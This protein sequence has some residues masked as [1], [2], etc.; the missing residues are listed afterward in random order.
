MKNMILRVVGI[1]LAITMML[2]PQ[3]MAA[4]LSGVETKITMADG[5]V[6]PVKI[7]GDEF[8]GFTETMDGYT[9]LCS[10]LG[11]DWFYAYRDTAGNLVQSTLRVG[12]ADPE[13]AMLKKHVRP[14]VT[15]ASKERIRRARQGMRSVTL[16]EGVW[17]TT[18]KRVGITIIV[19]FPDETTTFTSED[20]DRLLNSDGYTEYGNNGSVKAYF[21]DMSDNKLEY[22]NIV[23]GPFTAPEAKDYYKVQELTA[24]GYVNYRTQDLVK[25]ALVWADATTGFNFGNCDGNSDGVIDAVSLFYA[26]E[27]PAYIEGLNG[28]WP[29]QWS[30]T[31]SADG[32]EAKHYQISPLASSLKIAVFCHESMHMITNCND[33]YDYN[34]VSDGVGKYCIMAATDTMTNPQR[35]C[36][37]LRYR[38]GWLTPTDISKVEGGEY[39]LKSTTGNALIYKM[40]A[41]EYFMVENRQASGR[42][43]ALPDS[44]IMI[45]HCDHNGS[46]DYSQ[47]TTSLHYECSVEQADGKFDLEKKVGKYGDTNDLFTSS[48]GIFSDTSTPDATWW[49]GA[50]SS[51]KLSVNSPVA[52]AIAVR[53][54]SQAG[55]GTTT[56]DTGDDDDDDDTD[57]S[58]YEPGK[59][60]PGPT[61]DTVPQP[62]PSLTMLFTAEKNLYGISKPGNTI[63][64]GVK[65][66]PDGYGYPVDIYASVTLPDNSRLWV[67]GSGG[68]TTERTPIA[69]SVVTSA[70]Q[71]KT[72]FSM[73]LPQGLPHGTYRWNLY[74]VDRLCDPLNTTDLKAYKTALL[75]YEE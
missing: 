38:C 72:F 13:A 52:S 59:H 12:T 26:G 28:L 5:T 22:T 34:Y 75:N 68:L 41:T 27:E 9:I 3:L 39:T 63:K 49:S 40:S 58:W 21:Q 46:N 32:K 44:G 50:A 74:L 35:V 51:F 55:D 18:G 7:W 54:G 67:N 53:V 20:I 45:L 64:I 65:Y 25:Q 37:Y 31:F 10:G 24:F 48:F 42:D 15:K 43:S 23:I 66:D 69:E 19:N 70:I 16:G 61:Q 56:P 30:V 11:E 57:D 36:A 62:E 2:A 8:Q 4:P 14:A 73:V 33:L 71:Q 47:M 17:E 29:H 60:D 1:C 6:V